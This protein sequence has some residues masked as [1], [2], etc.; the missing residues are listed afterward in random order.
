[1]TRKQHWVPQFYLKQFANT[2]GTLYACHLNSDT[3]FIAKPEK[4]CGKRD[5]YEVRYSTA[6][7]GDTD[8]FFM[9]NLIESKLSEYERAISSKFKKLLD[10]CRYKRFDGKDFLDGR[11]ATCELAANL[12]V[13]HPDVMNA[14]RAQA[15]EASL[16]LEAN[17][18]NEFDLFMLNLADWHEDYQA[19]SELAIEAAALF[20][21]DGRVPVNQLIRYFNNKNL[22]LFEA[23]VG[24]TF[25]TTSRPIA[26][27]ETKE[28]SLDFGAAYMPLSD[29]YAAL[30]H[31]GG[32]PVSFRRLS[33]QHVSYLNR[34]ILSRCAD[35]D[36][37]M[38]RTKASLQHSV[39]EWKI[40][41]FEEMLEVLPNLV[42]E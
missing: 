39:Q 11:F 30:F 16:L 8:E 40:T 37:A 29:K 10:C 5:L 21:P 25:I 38:S 33:Y 26:V 27:I 34:L 1:M 41:W 42:C 9:Q 14:E 19:I 13:R 22:S 28:N 6:A 18:H 32:D 2:S 20:S 12:V 36:T 3:F 35:D 31:R 23:P 15:Q 7:K 24:T 17:L 4:L